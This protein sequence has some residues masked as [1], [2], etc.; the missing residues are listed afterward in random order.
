MASLLLAVVYGYTVR[1]PQDPIVRN[2]E[3]TIKHFC[4][5]IEPGTYLVDAFPSCKPFGLSQGLWC[6]R[7]Q[8]RHLP[9]WFPGAGFK[10]TAKAWYALVTDASEAPF[11]YA[12]GAK[13]CG[14][15][16]SS[17]VHSRISGPGQT[18]AALKCRSP[19]PWKKRG[20]SQG[21]R[22]RKV[23]LLHSI[24]W[25]V[26]PCTTFAGLWLIVPR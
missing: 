6:L 14:S 11:K 26:S 19:R 20:L 7:A 9:A 12:Q 24:L 3:E 5:T 2:T 8:V 1:G 25:S 4:T 21:G 22:G 23:G 15:T 18:E 16:M 10:G 17:P 13:V